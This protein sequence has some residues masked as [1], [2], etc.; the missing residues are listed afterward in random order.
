RRACASP[1]AGPRAAGRCAGPG[2]R[3][4]DASPLPAG[5]AVV[6]PQCD[7]GA[8]PDT[9]PDVAVHPDHLAYVIYT[10]GSTGRPKGAQLCHRQVVRLLRGT[11]GWFRFG[12][13]DVWTLFHSCA[14]DFSVWEL[15]GA[16]CTGG[17][18]V[19][20]P[21]WVSRSPQDF[22]A[23]LRTRR[24]TVLNQTPSAFGQLVGLPATCEP[25]PAGMPELSLRVVI[26]GGE[27]L[28]PQRLR[29]WIAH[30][31]D[32]RPERGEFVSGCRKRTTRPLVKCA[33]D[34]RY[35]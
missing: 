27:A 18:L 35:D 30:F 19:I 32:A 9:P 7:A 22:L 31:G 5:L 3:R 21:Y 33:F 23:L 17:Q 25:P 29:P 15:F 16:L 12:P 6:D 4:W 8:W 26:F 11:D 28:D 24:V 10:S 13:E 2:A 20:V 1:R 34:L 14:F